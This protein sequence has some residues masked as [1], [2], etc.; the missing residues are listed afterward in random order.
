MSL[1]AKVPQPSRIHPRADWTSSPHGAAHDDKPHP[2]L[3]VHITE[4]PGRELVD[5]GRECAALRAI[6]QYHMQ[7]RGWDDIGYSYLLCQP[8]SRATAATIY[9]GRGKTRIPASQQGAN[10][11]HWSVAVVASQHEHIMRR[12]L[13]AIAWLAAYLRPVKILPHSAQNSTDCPGDY[14]RAHIDQISHW[15][16]I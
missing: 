3:Y 16:G 1:P 9:V 14:L 12:S 4:S 13:V 2:R 11:G 10:H 5:P 6:R 8:W 15:A 7:A